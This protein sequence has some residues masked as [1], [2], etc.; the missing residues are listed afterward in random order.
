MATELLDVA[1]EHRLESTAEA[2]ERL[3]QPQPE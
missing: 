2:F 1:P 3:P